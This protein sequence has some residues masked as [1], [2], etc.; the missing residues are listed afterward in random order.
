MKTLIKSSCVITAVDDYCGEIVIDG[1]TETTVVIK[2]AAKIGVEIIT[3]SF[4]ILALLFL[5]AATDLAQT[6]IEARVD[7]FVKSEME[8]Q[9]IPGVSLAVIK[10]GKPL[11]VKGYGFAN[12]EHQVPVKP[13]TFFQS[14]SVGKQFTAMAVMLLVEDGKIELDQKIGKYLDVPEAWKNIT[15]RNLLTHTS[16]LPRNVDFDERRD[17]TD[18]ETWALI[19]QVSPT[20]SPGEIWRYSNLG[21][22][23]LGFLVTKVSGKPYYS[24]MQERVFK[25]LGM[26]TARTISEEDIVPNR[27]AGYRLV[28]G[29]VKNQEWVSP[30]MNSGPDGSFYFTIRDMVKWDDALSNGKLL[31]KASY[32]QMWTPVRLADGKEQTYGF[33][34]ALSR[35]NGK[36]VIAHGGS[37]Q[38]FKVIIARYPDNGLSVIVFANSADAN[39]DGIASRIAVLMDPSLKP[40]PIV[41]PD[42]KLSADLRTLFEK[43]LAGTIDETRFTPRLAAA[44]KDPN[45][46]L[47]AQLKTTAAIR[48]FELLDTREVGD[49]KGWQYAVEFGSISVV[50]E[51]ARDKD[52][53]IFHFVIHPQ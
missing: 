40:I 1:E 44:L 7:K 29:E 35:L 9:K 13:D 30:S 23:T 43:I 37:W 45:H 42:P 22:L 36:R 51:L 50:L 12:L 39:T 33:G 28:N 19:K 2:R 6:P 47:L 25:P 14:A 49:I 32:E 46:K 10:D 38:G 17:Y 53:K 41:D 31:S 8:R 18:T 4:S 16:G 34:W 24:F 27:A 52:G 3:R 15:V 5:I 20:N 26:T 11:I 21:Y 48:K